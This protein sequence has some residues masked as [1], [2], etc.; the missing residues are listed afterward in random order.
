MA[1]LHERYDDDDDDGDDDDDVLEA[2]FCCLILESKGPRKTS[3]GLR[4]YVGDILTSSTSIIYTP[5][6]ID[7]WS[8]V[9]KIWSH[10]KF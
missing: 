2:K 9:N 8:Q 5:V 3:S 4:G 1:Q 6:Y 10:M 7:A